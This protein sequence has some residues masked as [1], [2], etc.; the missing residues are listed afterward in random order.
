MLFGAKHV[1]PALPP[2]F[3]AITEKEEKKRNADTRFLRGAIHHNFNEIT[4][5][6]VEA[7][8][9]KSSRGIK[10]RLNFFDRVAAKRIE[11][12]SFLNDVSTIH[13]VP[14]KLIGGKTGRELRRDSV[15]LRYINDSAR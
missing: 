10:T 5:H 3:S 7:P 15:E 4:R 13:R 8:W 2:F 9:K 11:R 12:D 14:I 1:F 6:E